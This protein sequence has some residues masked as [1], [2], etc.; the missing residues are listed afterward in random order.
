MST[1]TTAGRRGVVP[2]VGAIHL[3]PL[4]L[5]MCA[6]PA[7]AQFTSTTLDHPL[8]GPGGTVVHDFSGDRFVGTY[9]DPAGASHGFTYDGATW[10]TLDH[11][12]AA[13]PGGTA[14]YGVSSGHVT[15][16]FVDASGQTFGY[17]YDGT[18]WRT[19]AR[20]PVAGGPVDTFARGVS[21]DTVVG[22]AIERLSTRGFIF[23]AGIVTDLIAEG[24]TGTFPD[25]VDGGRVVGWVEDLAGT[26]G[27]VYD[28]AT[29]RT[30]DHPLGLPLGT[31]A[32]GI[33]GGNVVGTYVSFPQ[34]AARGFLYDGV[35]FQPIDFPG[36]TSTSV[37]GI[38][39]LR[40]VGSYDDAAGRRHGFVITVP[41]PSLAMVPL[42]CLWLLTRRRRRREARQS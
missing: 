37:Q 8:A 10:T 16:T 7:A 21:G 15:G 26:H 29:L 17:L 30:F 41:E 14:A 27:F 5:A 13:G 3:T 33:D 38:E 34:G 39:G 40:V 1:N 18:N 4:L 22:Y 31:F 11:P 36:A 19:I 25:D 23:N 42:G 9:L 12:S 20:P 2:I 35:R 6:A 32:T 28:G 24:A